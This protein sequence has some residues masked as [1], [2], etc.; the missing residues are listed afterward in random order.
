MPAMSEAVGTILPADS[1]ASEPAREPDL[2]FLWDF[3]YPALRST[4]IVGLHL[5]KAMLLEV[6]LVL[7]RASEAGC[8]ADRP[9]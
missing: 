5:A 6:P 7:G 9:R 8:P 1:A 3:W 2:G 4:E